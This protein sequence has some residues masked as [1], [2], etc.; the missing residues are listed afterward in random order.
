[1]TLPFHAL[2]A[3]ATAVLVLIH[4]IPTVASSRAVQL[5]AEGN[6]VNW[7]DVSDEDG[8]DSTLECGLWLA[9]STLKGAG[10]GMYAGIDYKTGQEVLPIGDLVV[11]IPDID[12]HNAFK[13]QHDPESFLWNHYT[14][15][16]GELMNNEGLQEVNFASQGLG[17][18]ANCFLPL[19]NTRLWYPQQIGTGLHRSSDPGAG[20]NTLFQRKSTARFDIK[21]GSELFVTCT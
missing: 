9:P 20:A 5:D 19:Y 16:G 14:W 6:A 3:F 18:A 17:S 11:A 21:A 12:R 15:D 8:D 4:E 2:C 7:S 1:M 13:P 10:L